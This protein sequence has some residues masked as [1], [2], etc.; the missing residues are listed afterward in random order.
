MIADTFSQLCRTMPI[1][2]LVMILTLIASLISIRRPSVTLKFMLHPYST[3][4]DK[5]YYRFF[6]ADFIHN[7]VVHL[8]INEYLLY[9]VSGRLEILLNGQKNGEF[10]FCGIYFTS[11]L[12]ASV[13]T[14][15]LNRKS[16]DYSSAGASGTLMG[17]LLSYMLLAPYKIGFYLPV[18]GGV[19]NMISA[20][21]VILGVT[22][23]Q[24]R[25]KHSFINHELHF[26]GALGGTAAT[27]IIF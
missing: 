5:E 15:I 9:F 18:I 12:S 16:F 6:T 7:D 13:I 26:F 4:K 14:S 17:C 11:M 22:I 27:L 10:L 23:Y 2:L 1:T 19:N 20:L 8:G 25:T 3:F 21:L 24:I